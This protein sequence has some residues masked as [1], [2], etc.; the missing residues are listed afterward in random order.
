M[1][2]YMEMKAIL[3]ATV[4][5]LALTAGNTASAAGVEGYLCGT[6][7][8]EL[9]VRVNANSL[10]LIDPSAEEKAPALVTYTHVD[11]GA[12]G[13]FTVPLTTD[14]G[15]TRV[16]DANKVPFIGATSLAIVDRLVVTIADPADPAEN[17]PAS[18]TGEMTLSK[19]GGETQHEALT[20]V[21]EPARD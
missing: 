14:S 16:M 1:N 17:A 10:E 11:H 3:V 21:V 20:C 18:F 13:V 9:E 8:Q 4:A 15:N 7:D 12:A 2:K 6:L 19:A 5:T